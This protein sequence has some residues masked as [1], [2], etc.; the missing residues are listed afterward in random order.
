MDS[1][2]NILF[3]SSWFPT[4]D[5]PTF[6]N[7]VKI[8]AQT[9][10]LLHQVNIIYVCKS[11]QFDSKYH[12]EAEHFDQLNI[13]T[14]YF[15]PIK[16]GL[17]VLDVVFNSIRHFKTYLKQV[18]P[19]SEQA[20]L[21]H[22]NVV[23]PIG[24]IALSL[25][26]KY[27]LKYVITEHWTIYL[28]E[29]RRLLNGFKGLIFKLIIKNASKIIPVSA[30]LKQ[31]MLECDMQGQ[32]ALVSNTINTSLFNY[33]QKSKTD[34]FKF[35]HISTL[36][37]EHKNGTGLL[38]AY[39][40][41]LDTGK[42]YHLTIISDGDIKPIENYAKSLGIEPKHLKFEGKQDPS[43]IAEYLKISDACVQFSNYETFGIVAAEALCCGTP[44]IST[45]VGFLTEFLEE[46]V[47]LFVGIGNE[48]ELSQAMLNIQNIDF[49]HK[50]NSALFSKRYNPKRI[51][52]DY[53]KIYSDVLAQ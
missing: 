52:H 11:E 29:N 35:L 48:N 26:W 3:I 37:D 19:F 42:A 21:V 32:Y 4:K 20:D 30:A 45:R 16:T 24:L 7:F 51:A 44:V 12:T 17:K 22:A 27:H 38:R 39:K 49:D 9:I 40:R 18:K 13:Y 6:G 2:L 33:Q 1:K 25:K 41:L 15:R 5:K 43:G 31:M 50:G 28:P 46:K 14:T 53:S 23:F 47:G 34:V 36:V 10:A 8:H